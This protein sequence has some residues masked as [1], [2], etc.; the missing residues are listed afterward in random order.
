MVSFLVGF[1]GKSTAIVEAGDLPGDSAMIMG[2]TEGRWR[3][4]NRFKICLG[5]RVQQN[6]Q[7][8]LNIQSAVYGGVNYFLLSAYYVQGTILRISHVLS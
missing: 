1:H 8:S 2:L 3:G 5:C 7:R 4:N 6:S